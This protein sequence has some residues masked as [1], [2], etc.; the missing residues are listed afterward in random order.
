MKCEAMITECVSAQNFMRLGWAPHPERCE[1]EATLKVT[2][3]GQ[4]TLL[5]C[6]RCF[7]EFRKYATLPWTA[8]NL[9]APRGKGRKADVR[10]L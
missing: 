4:G 6:D 9:N 8:R 10:S 1:N 3:K 7:P 5:L 2:V